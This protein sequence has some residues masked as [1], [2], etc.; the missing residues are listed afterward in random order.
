MQFDFQNG[1]DSVVLRDALGE[2]RDAL[3]YG[4]FGVDD[5][6]AGEGTAA[7]D[8]AAGSS[9]ARLF[10]NV[11]T[12]DNA[13]DFA[14]SAMPTPGAADFAVVPEP[15]TP[16]LMGLG[17]IGLATG[18]RRTRGTGRADVPLQGR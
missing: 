10:A 12:G 9:L 15:G 3:G 11:D 6:F 2:V 18:A 1:P 8:P 7:P 4:V 16:L 13:V 17:L 14:A 5:V